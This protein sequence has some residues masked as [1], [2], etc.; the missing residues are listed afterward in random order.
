[1]I[2]IILLVLIIGFQ[3][4]C[5][6]QNVFCEESDYV[7]Y[8]DNSIEDDYNYNPK[9]DFNENSKFVSP[10]EFENAIKTVEKYGMSN[11]KRK[12]LENKR[13]QQ[14]KVEKERARLSPMKPSPDA[15]L[16]LPASVKYNDINIETGFYLLE[17]KFINNKD[18]VIF[19]QANNNV[20]EV[21]V[22]SSTKQPEKLFESNAVVDIVDDN[23]ITITLNT[24]D[25]QYTILLQRKNPIIK[26]K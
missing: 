23:D 3:L 17:H 13:I 18:V 4:L 25:H 24:K 8:S 16:R 1:M 14:E 11:R 19:K 22:T 21:P 9:N 15:L 20:V 10:T 6:Q 2:K 7:D 26:P 5:C 12:E